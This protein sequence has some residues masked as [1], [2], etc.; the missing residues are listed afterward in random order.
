MYLLLYNKNLIAYLFFNNNNS[1]ISGFST[2]SGQ[3]RYLCYLSKTN[4]A[5]IATRSAGVA[6]AYLFA[7]VY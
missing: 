3:T 2:R 6:M 4:I 5:R 1:I 7:R